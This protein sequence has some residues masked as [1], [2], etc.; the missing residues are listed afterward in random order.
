[1]EIPAG[2]PLSVAAAVLAAA[3]LAAALG[4]A[5]SGDL[6]LPPAES[7][8]EGS[9]AAPDRAGSSSEV[10]LAR[11]ADASGDIASA[12]AHYR[13]AAIRNP[14]IVDPRSPEFL[15]PAFEARLKGWIV[16]LKRGELRGG[17]K[18][19]SDAAFLFRRMYGGCG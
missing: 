13:A 3:S 18:A 16:G 7:S 14:R 19:L 11:N 10:A 5:V 15:G 9:G 4:V 8:P 12:L 6:R 1:M 2:K 17:G